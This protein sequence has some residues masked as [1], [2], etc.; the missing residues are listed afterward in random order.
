MISTISPFYTAASYKCRI[1]MNMK[2]VRHQMY[3]YFVNTFV[4]MLYIPRH[5]NKILLGY[6]LKMLSN[7]VMDNSRGGV[8][9]AKPSD[10]LTNEAN[11]R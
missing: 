4:G 9:E 8:N 6:K 3:I 2:Y 7:S 1:R 5:E 10:A 11:V